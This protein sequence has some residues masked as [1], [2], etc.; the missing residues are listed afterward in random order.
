MDA[1]DAAREA[2]DVAGHKLGA[3]IRQQR[4]T[5]QLS[6]RKLARMADVSDPYLSQIE[7]GLRRPSADI[8][9]RLAEALR[10]SAESLYYQAGILTEPDGDLRA[11]IRAEP[12]LT[13]SQKRALVEIYE[14][15][16]TQNDQQQSKE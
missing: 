14:S 4:T 9:Q 16:R 5:A 11:R 10:I 13:E 12:S 1:K 6:L 7:R 15:F 8:L 2:T 3:F